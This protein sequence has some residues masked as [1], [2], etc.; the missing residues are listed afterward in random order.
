M[1][2]VSAVLGTARSAVRLKVKVDPS[3]YSEVT[4]RSPFIACE[5]L[6]EIA[7]PK[8]VPACGLCVEESACVNFSKSDIYMTLACKFH[9]IADEVHNDL[10]HTFFV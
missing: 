7:R 6:W 2:G 3:P 4:V 8:P 9:G 10:T 5:S 1:T